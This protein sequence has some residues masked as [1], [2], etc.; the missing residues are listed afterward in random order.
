GTA[1]RAMARRI[2]VSFRREGRITRPEAA[3][4]RLLQEGFSP[5]GSRQ[6]RARLLGDERIR[7]RGS[8][9]D[10]TSKRRRQ[11]VAAAEATFEYDVESILPS[12]PIPPA[13]AP[14][15]ATALIKPHLLANLIASYPEYWYKVRYC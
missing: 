1:L 15:I 13:E 14:G 4:S 3:L 5:L 11:Q 10:L 9:P 8:E 7:R 6:S 12:R 2:Q